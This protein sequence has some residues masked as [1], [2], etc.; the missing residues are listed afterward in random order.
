MKWKSG[1]LSSRYLF[2]KFDTATTIMEPSKKIAI[3]LKCV[4]TFDSLCI[5]HSQNAMEGLGCTK[6][7]PYNDSQLEAVAIICSVLD[8]KT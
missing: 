3:V 6:L 7:E 2:E 4:N 1:E 5:I 8:G